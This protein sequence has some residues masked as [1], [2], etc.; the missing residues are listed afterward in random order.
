MAKRAAGEISMN[1]VKPDSLEVLYFGCKDVA[2]HYLY[3]KFTPNMRY[4][5]TPWGKHLDG[6]LLANNFNTTPTGK[7]SVS[8]K[9]GW[10]AIAFWDRSG[11][12]RGGSNSVFLIASDVTGDQLLAMARV[13]WPEIFDRWGRT[14]LELRIEPL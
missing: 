4:E 3:S 1:L 5:S 13:Q 10:T 8:H 9:D 12:S 2:G 11:D 14:G 6:G 7:V